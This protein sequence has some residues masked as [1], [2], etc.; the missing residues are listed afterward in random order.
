MARKRREENPLP[1]SSGDEHEEQ[2][3]DSR[4]T[5]GKKR[6]ETTTGD[7]QQQ[8]FSETAELLRLLNMPIDILHEVRRS[9]LHSRSLIQSG[10]QIFSLTH[11]KDLLSI[12]W[13]SKS[14]NGFLTSR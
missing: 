13:T 7:K 14:L 1:A 11:P 12:S 3:P 8:E 10:S 5:R 4:K 6:A 9:L 2:A